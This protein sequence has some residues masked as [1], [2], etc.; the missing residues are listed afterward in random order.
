MTQGVGPEFKL[1]YHTQKKNFFKRLREPGM[2]A[3]TCN[4]STQRQEEHKSKTSLDYTGPFSLA[5]FVTT[6]Y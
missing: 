2:V 5:R 4:P 1:Q 6:L 3:G